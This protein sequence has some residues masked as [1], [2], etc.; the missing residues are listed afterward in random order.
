MT[1]IKLMEITSVDD[2]DEIPKDTYLQHVDIVEIVDLDGN[3][4]EPVD[5]PDPWDEL[6]IAENGGANL[7]GSN[8][9]EIGQ[10]VTG[11]TAVFIGGNPE[12]TTYRSRWQSRTTSSD[13]WVNSNW[14][15]TTNEKNDHAY[16][17]LKPGQI[18]FQS[19]GR[20]TSID[21]VL[22][23]NSFTSVKEVPFTEI[24]TVA[25]SPDSAA[26]AVMGSQTFTAV[27]T[28]GDATDLTYKWNVRSGNAQ[29]DTPDNQ[30][31]VTYTF[32][33]TGQ[34]QIQCTVSSANSSN[35]PLSNLSMVLVS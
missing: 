24:G 32:I 3:P 22:Q 30:A 1:Y 17:I 15:S 6:A 21:P 12:T 13:S 23:I 27:V 10:V 4:W 14:M 31:T 33:G 16:P 5:G 25:V 11:K 34:T 29:I 2:T 9:Y 8:V 28:G 7:L 20:D 19:Q 35:S 18:R 26:V